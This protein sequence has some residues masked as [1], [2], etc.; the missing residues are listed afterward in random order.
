MKAALKAGR[1]SDAEVPAAF[2][3]R[4]ATIDFDVPSLSDAVL[5]LSESAEGTPWEAKTAALATLLP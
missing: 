2:R 4:A 1:L 5:T 3:E